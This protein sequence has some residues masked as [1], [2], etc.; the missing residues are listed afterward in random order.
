[1]F[2][3]A[4]T[5]N[6]DGS[7]ASAV[8]TQIQPDGSTLTLDYS[9]A[10]DHDGRLTDEGATAS[11]TLG[12]ADAPTD[13]SEAAAQ[14]GYADHYQF[15]LNGNRITDVHTGGGSGIF[16]G[17]T[18]DTYDG[19]D[20][21]KTSVAGS[22]TT[23][24]DYD[25][26]GSQT[27][28]E[29]N[30][31]VATTYGYD[32]R[33]KMV[34][35]T[36]A[37]GADTANGQTAA[38]GGQSATYVYDD[39]G[40]RV[41]ETTGGVTTYYLTDTQNPTGYGQPIE[42]RTSPTGAPTVTYLIGDRVL[43]QVDAGGTPTYI[44]TD[45]HGSTAALTTAAGAVTAAYAYT[46]Y[47]DALGFTLASA[48]TVYLFGGDAVY[49]PASGLYLHGDGTR[50]RDGFRFVEADT[51]GNGT[52]S[53]P[54]SLH[55]Y[56]YAGGNPVMYVDP[57]GHDFSL[58]SSLVAIGITGLLGGVVNGA[59][60]SIQAGVG[61]RIE[62]FENGYAKGYISAAVAA[63]LLIYSRGKVPLPVA[64]AMGAFLADTVVE[65]LASVAS[66]GAD[67][68]AHDVLEHAAV[69][70]LLAGAVSWAYGKA[71]LDPHD[72]N[73]A[74][75][76]LRKANVRAIAAKLP[77]TYPWS[78]SEQDFAAFGK[79]VLLSQEAQRVFNPY[80][81]KVVTLIA[82]NNAV[83]SIIIGYAYTIFDAGQRALKWVHA[84]TDL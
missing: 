44:L 27:D 17:T 2:N 59:I 20:Q 51:E 52:N 55:K 60:S 18:T 84:A 64:N 6:H 83:D 12:T 47:G 78:T 80:L 14:D 63:S 1:V 32:V 46:A 56:L 30:G 48:G 4:F 9:W 70:A 72:L 53:E 49:D 36:A 40:D 22:T 16:V 7:R 74:I 34:S 50:G 35:A 23:T 79:S 73:T 39:A 11:G 68:S 26:N 61:H 25:A 57:S 29:V 13:A 37:G 82:A 38:P 65:G 33:N 42:Q 76:Q 75:E 45:G 28:S 43:G 67:G 3:E 8:E 58:S 19:D 69:D 31:V 66:G 15:D 5:L 21:L 71:F 10:Y 77:A 62:G 41:A 54:I 24:Y 81:T